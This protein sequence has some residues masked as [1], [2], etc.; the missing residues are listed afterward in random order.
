MNVVTISPKFQVV[1]PKMVRDQLHLVKSTLGPSGPHGILRP[2][3]KINV[4]S[5][6]PDVRPAGVGTSGAA[7][8][9]PLADASSSR[10]KGVAHVRVPA[11]GDPA[12]GGGGGHATLRI[13]G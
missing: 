2:Q 1:I 9:C 3:L 11:G 12:V 10:R 5:L 7:R 4:E 6:T 13:H 8:T